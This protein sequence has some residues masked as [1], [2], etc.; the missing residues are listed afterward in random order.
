MYFFLMMYNV[1]SYLV[2]ADQEF[3]SRLP[4]PEFYGYHAVNEY[5]KMKN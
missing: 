2:K 5:Y 3:E 4:M 1:Y